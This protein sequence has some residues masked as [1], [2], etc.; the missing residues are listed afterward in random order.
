MIQH[1]STSR[2]HTVPI[3]PLNLS[4][5]SSWKQKAATKHFWRGGCCSVEIFLT[6]VVKLLWGRSEQEEL[7]ETSP[8]MSWQ[9]SSSLAS[10]YAIFYYTKYSCQY[11]VKQRNLN[12]P[13]SGQSCCYSELRMWWSGVWLQ[14]QPKGV[15]LWHAE[16]VGNVQ[17]GKGGLGLCSGKPVWNQ[18]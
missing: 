17:M 14:I 2:L 9:R 15:T 5:L 4:L 18:S 6:V 16:I 12:V 11:L 3:Y 13:R 1:W 7:L 10:D 8:K